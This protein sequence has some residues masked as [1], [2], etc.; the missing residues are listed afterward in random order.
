MNLELIRDIL[1]DVEATA[2]GKVTFGFNYPER[3]ERTDK[4]I[5]CHVE[6][7]I[8]EGYLDGSVIPG[9]EG[10]VDC[11]VRKITWKGHEFLANA[12]NDTVWK[13]VISEAKE[14]GTSTS[15]VVIQGLLAKAAEKFAGL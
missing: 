4:E 3:A 12:K 11:A 9:D 2:P 14:K 1:I 7:L 8:D 5:L 6:L 13:R 10:P 15:M